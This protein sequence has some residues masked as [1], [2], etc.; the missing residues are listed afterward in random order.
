MYNRVNLLDPYQS[1]LRMPGATLVTRLKVYDTVT[2]DG[3]IGGTPHFHFL[4]TEMYFVLAGS[5]TVEM[6]DMRGFTQVELKPFSALVFSPGTIHRLV[7]PH[8]DLE[9]LVVMQNSGLPE[10]G[11]NVVAFTEDILADAARFSEAMKVQSFEDAYRRRDR[12]VEGFLSLKAAFEVDQDQ[13]QMALQRVYTYAAQRL[14]AKR[15]QWQQVIEQ[16]AERAAH[17]SL[18][19][20]QALAAGDVSYLSH[21]RHVLIE[22]GEYKTPGFCG[23]LNR[24]FDPAT[25]TM[26]GVAHS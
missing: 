17:E 6:I 14:E 15:S 7:N 12:G 22:A 5:G 18:E 2:I 1:H 26:E 13:G 25:L 20:V 16:G 21:A 9:L 23:R 10:R 3:K 24:Y 8:G 11:D 4:C 19:Q